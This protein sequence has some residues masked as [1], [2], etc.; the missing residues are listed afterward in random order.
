MKDKK[1]RLRKDEVLILRTCNNDG[2][3]YNGFQ[4]PKAGEVEAKDWRD[5]YKCGG[6]LHGHVWCPG[7]GRKKPAFACSRRGPS[8]G[9]VPHFA[10]TF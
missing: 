1:L 4:W 9:I 10:W 7:G 2:T 5:D 3:S 8:N 6:G